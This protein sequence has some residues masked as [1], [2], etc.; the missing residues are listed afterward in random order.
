MAV[1]NYQELIVWQKSMALAKEVYQIVKKLPK[2]E[3][4]SLSVQ[5]RRA[6][7]SIPSNIAEGQARNSTKEFIQ[8]LS[9]ARGSKAEIQT[10][11][12]LC[13]EIGYLANTDI[14]EA[15]GLAEE[16]GKMLSALIQKLTTAH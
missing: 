6:A 14:L 9:V 7:V 5:M 15:M 10:Q 4:Y 3:L 11:M 8:F 13:V 16:V 12:L 1:Q 2:E